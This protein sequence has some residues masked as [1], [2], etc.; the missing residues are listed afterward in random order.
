MAAL[1]RSGSSACDCKSDAWLN[2]R[3]DGDGRAAGGRAGGRRV[4]PG[5]ASAPG[6][7]DQRPLVQERDHLLPVGRHLHGCQWR[8]HRRFHR[9]DAAARLPAR[10]RHHRDLAD[11]VS[12][13]AA[14]RRRLRRRRLLRRRSALRHP[15]RFRRIHPRRQAAR[16]P[17]ADRSRGQSHLERASLV[18]GGAPRP[19]LEIPRL[20]CLVEEEAGEREQRHGVSR[21]AEIDL[22]LRRRG[23]GL[24]LPPLLRFPARP[25]HLKP[26]GAGRDPQDHG[27]LDS[28]RRLGVPHGCGAVHHRDQGAG[29]QKAR[30]AVRH[31]P[32]VPRI[33][34]MAAGRL[35]SCWRKPMCCRTPTWNISATTATAC[36]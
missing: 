31:A 18:Q 6:P 3:P 12:G 2:E 36:T 24:V 35:P 9:A 22:E 11:A 25:Q 23:Q 26:G 13:L 16:H 27:L 30:G 29:R 8:R 19:E 10:A 14:S 17:G 20:V 15:R 34:A 5:L 21:R 4:Y 33:P 7:H 32:H 1:G 28:A